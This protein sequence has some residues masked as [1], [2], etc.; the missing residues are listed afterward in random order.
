MF[1]KTQSAYNFIYDQ[2][3]S[4]REELAK[5]ENELEKFK[6]TNNTISLEDEIPEL[7][8]K[9]IEYEEQVEQLNSNISLFIEL[10]EKEEKTATHTTTNK[11]AQQELEAS[12]LADAIQQDED[13]QR[14]IQAFNA[15]VIAGSLNSQEALYSTKTTGEPNHD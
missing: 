10:S 13:S 8:R 14:I 3:Q 9:I 7:N 11:T 6:K 5:S 15:K 4:A 12:Q 2:V 1:D